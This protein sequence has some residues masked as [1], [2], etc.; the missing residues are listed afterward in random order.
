MSKSDI[1]GEKQE[2]E[3]LIDVASFLRLLWQQKWVLLVS[4]VAFSTVVMLW[5]ARQ[6]KVYE[7]IGTLQYDPNPPRPLP[8]SV[9]DIS[10]E[11]P[12]YLG[13]QEFY[14]TQNQI[15]SSRVL[16]ERVVEQLGLQANPDFL[17]I[18]EDE[19]DAWEGA[20]I[21]EAALALQLRL[22]VR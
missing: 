9:E 3:S 11:A 1:V 4:T 21:S 12:S 10:Q 19:R 5:T 15:L 14:K 16:M 22:G 7:A 8:G 17:Y 18:P 20:S 2:E 13:Q 6:P